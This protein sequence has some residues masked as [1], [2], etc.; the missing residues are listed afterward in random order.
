MNRKTPPDGCPECGPDGCTRLRAQLEALQ[1]IKRL[2][3]GPQITVDDRRCEGC[4]SHARWE[5]QVG[6]SH[7]RTA[8][9]RY[10]TPC[11]IR[12]VEALLETPAQGTLVPLTHFA[13]LAH[14]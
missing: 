7:A 9:I 3:A 1:R 6:D 13:P 2:M 4:E 11:G 8:R 12:A 5:L 14:A 10:C